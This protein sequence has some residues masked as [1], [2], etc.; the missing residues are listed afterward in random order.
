MAG[1]GL[2]WVWVIFLV[3]HGLVWVRLEDHD[4]VVIVYDSKL[5]WFGFGLVF[6]HRHLKTEVK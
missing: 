6:F 1:V 3:F 5:G 2:D 4:I